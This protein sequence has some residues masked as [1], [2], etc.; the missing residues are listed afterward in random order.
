MGWS[1]VCLLLLVARQPPRLYLH[2]RRKNIIIIFFFAVVATLMSIS[3]TSRTQK[4]CSRRTVTAPL[5]SIEFSSILI[6]CL[7]SLLSDNDYGWA[8]NDYKSN[9]DTDT[10]LFSSSSS[11]RRRPGFWGLPRHG[12]A[13]RGERLLIAKRYCMI[14]TFCRQIIKKITPVYE[15]TKSM[16]LLFS[17]TK[18]CTVLFFVSCQHFWSSCF[19]HI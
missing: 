14:L 18:C 8:S 9:M 16:A 4:S 10:L 12:G 1:I 3:T 6:C 17:I 11:S 15:K 7:L 2:I 5:Y 13:T 19:F